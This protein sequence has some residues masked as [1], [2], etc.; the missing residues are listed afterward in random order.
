MNKKIIIAIDGPAGSG[1]TTTA[2]EVATRL[3][4][5]YIDTGAMYRAITYA[6]LQSGLE[7]TDENLTKILLDNKIELKQSDDG[8]KT[9]LNGKDVSK[10]IRTRDVTQNVS[11]ISTIKIVRQ[12]L[13][14]QQRE[15]GKVGGVVMDGRD[16]GTT[17]FPKAELKVF[18]IASI[19]ARA[20][21]RTKELKAKG[22]DFSIEEIKK[23][24]EQRDFIDSNRDVSPLR[25]ADDAIEIN[26]S[27]MTIEEQTQKIIDLANNIINKS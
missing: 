7:M 23:Q 15:L 14:E 13:V 22:E 20:E 11:P 21:R 12:I 25:K 1:K 24:I 9:F 5:I 3:N 17:V 6:W 19:E 18:L 26:T 27:H 16:I 2:K 10:E 4:Y 8:Q